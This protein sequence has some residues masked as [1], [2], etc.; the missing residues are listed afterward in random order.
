MNKKIKRNDLKSLKKFKRVGVRTGAMALLVTS[1]IGNSNMMINGLTNPIVARA[2]AYDLKNATNEQKNNKEYVLKAVEQNGLMLEHASD[3]LKNDKEVVLKAVAQNGLALQFVSKN[4]QDDKEVVLKGVVQNRDALKYASDKLKNDKDF[5][6]KVIKDNSENFKY[7]SNELKE[8]KDFILDIVKENPSV[9]KHVN[10]DLKNDKDF[11]NKAIKNNI[12]ALSFVGDKLKKDKAFVLQ[13]LKNNPGNVRLLTNDLKHDKDFLLKAI[14]ENK[15]V[16]QYLDND[17]KNDKDFVF[18]SIKI[19]PTIYYNV[20]DALK[21]EIKNDEESMFTISTT[22]PNIL[23]EIKSDKFK[24]N[25]KFILRCLTHGIENHGIPIDLISIFNKDFYN[26]KDVIDV[27]VEKDNCN[28]SDEFYK[29]LFK[30]KELFTWYLEKHGVWDGKLWK[31]I[32][33]DTHS[34][35]L[36]KNQVVTLDIKN[37]KGHLPYSVIKSIPSDVNNNIRWYF[38][39]YD[40]KV[41]TNFANDIKVILSS[42][43]LAKGNIYVSVDSTVLNSNDLKS[44]ID[45][46][47]EY[48][49]DANTQV[50]WETDELK[51][52]LNSNIKKEK[53]DN[54]CYKITIPKIKVINDFE[55]NNLAKMFKL[56]EIPDRIKNNIDNGINILSKYLSEEEMKPIIDLKNKNKVEEDEN[57]I[58]LYLIDKINYN[59]DS[60]D[61]K[62]KITD[63]NKGNQDLFNR[64]AYTGVSAESIKNLNNLSVLPVLGAFTTSY[65]ETP[66]F[67]IELTKNVNVPFNT[68]KQYVK[69]LEEGKTNVLKKGKNG[70]KKITI[71]TTEDG[72]IET[73]EET[74]TEPINALVEVGTKGTEPIGTIENIAK[75]TTIKE[76]DIPFKIEKKD[77]KELEVGKTRVIKKGENGRKRI[78]TTVIGDNKPTVTEEIIKKPINEV[79]EVGTKT[80]IPILPKID[81]ITHKTN[82]K[83]N[84]EGLYDGNY[85]INTVVKI[86]DVDDGTI[87]KINATSEDS[88]ETLDFEYIKTPSDDEIKEGNLLNVIF[89]ESN[90]GFD[91][92]E[93]YGTG[94]ISEN[95]EDIGNTNISPSGDHDYSKIYDEDYDNYNEEDNNDD[96]DDYYD[97][98]FSPEFNEKYKDLLKKIKKIIGKIDKRNKKN[99]DNNEEPKDAATNTNNESFNETGLSAEAD[100]TYANYKDL[101]NN[102]EETPNK[103]DR[104]KKMNKYDGKDPENMPNYTSDTNTNNSGTNID[105]KANIN[106]NDTNNN[107]NVDDNELDNSNKNNIYNDTKELSIRD[108]SKS[109]FWYVLLSLSGA[110]LLIGLLMGLIKKFF[111]KKE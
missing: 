43:I 87:Y 13:D 60:K 98:N 23:K 78:I 95:N 54:N 20:S 102:V 67:K 34:F 90:D 51:N 29:N 24:N 46:N 18:K 101:L 99:Q 4:L 84:Q 83:P 68:E 52:T 63:L 61:T 105:S 79:V 15:L 74:I 50:F 33:D 12:G 6:K 39:H 48:D 3:I 92:Y 104:R 22:C 27:A 88:K 96:N 75:K 62:L 10:E 32:K 94:I 103:I 42:N 97:E 108:K 109:R 111:N 44:L 35:D 81:N 21:E 80:V 9:L 56:T 28:L 107:N 65:E 53:I 76:E 55:E 69:T 58:Y 110:G 31:E 19:D 14:K 86:K 1:F 82:L 11:M 66:L 37:Y 93:I 100:E 73:K 17:V 91:G 77:S 85:K 59:I 25:K 2:E 64:F 70:L 41:N 7:A 26:D 49:L 47:S 36:L 71:K 106:E 89:K 30:N 38:K 40:P 45:S 72:E 57:N 5:M 8:D 16:Y